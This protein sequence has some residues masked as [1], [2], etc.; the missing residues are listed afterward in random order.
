MNKKVKIILLIS[1][2]LNLL[3]VSF[4]LGRVLGFVKPPRPN[5]KEIMHKRE[6]DVISVLPPRKQE[7]A[8][9]SFNNL[10]SLRKSNFLEIRK[11]MRAVEQT[12][13]QRKF[14]KEAFLNEMTKLN[15]TSNMMRERSNLEI[16][17]FLSKLTRKE[18][19]AIVAKTKQQMRMFKK[20]NSS[21]KQ[22]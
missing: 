14:N 1:I 12:V 11:Q 8:L 16:A 2:A 19:I 5:F 3:F 17:E 15:Y 22:D 21:T 18:R 7:L 10:R 13:I 9:Q 4:H 20:V 6:Q